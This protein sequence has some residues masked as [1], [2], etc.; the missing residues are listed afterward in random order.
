MAP[1][2]H[3][4][5]SSTMDI[6]VPEPWSLPSGPSYIYSPLPTI[7]FSQSSPTSHFS[8]SFSSQTSSSSS[9][10][11]FEPSFY[12]PSL[13]S[14]QETPEHTT[15]PYIKQE[16]PESTISPSIKQE[17]PAP[18]PPSST[19]RS[20]Y[21]GMFGIRLLLTSLPRKNFS[22][23]TYERRTHPTRTPTIS[24]G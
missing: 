21:E 8:S 24:A 15:K 7:S 18:R 6:Q 2:H 20:S 10:S 19:G 16:S 1:I 14:K 4:Q 12:Q 3:W 22:K 13:Y 5:R 9:N 11:C 23:L 17:S